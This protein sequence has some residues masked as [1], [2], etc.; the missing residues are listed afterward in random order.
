MNFKASCPPF[1]K[2][3]GIV[4]LSLLAIFVAG[5]ICEWKLGDVWLY[6]ALLR[7]VFFVF[8]VLI[9]LPL[10]FI[11]KGSAFDCSGHVQGKHWSGHVS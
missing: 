8:Y 3:A 11:Q 1:L 2:R 10:H 9:L 4:F 7:P 5:N 6:T